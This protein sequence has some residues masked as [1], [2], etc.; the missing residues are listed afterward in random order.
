M[1]IG[2]FLMGHPPI[3]QFLQ[4]INVKNVHPVASAGIQTH[5]LLNFSLLPKLIG[6]GT[7]PN[8]SDLLG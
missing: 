3:K 5:N 7:R 8:W 4:Q 1:F 6:Q 2:Q